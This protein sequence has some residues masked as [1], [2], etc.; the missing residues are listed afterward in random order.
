[1]LLDCR[2]RSGCA[3]RP[4]RR[5]RPPD[6]PG[7]RDGGPGC[8]PDHRSRDGPHRSQHDR[9]RYGAQGCIAGATLSFCLERNKRPCDYSY[10]KPFLH[11]GS[12]PCVPPHPTAKLRRHEGRA[13]YPNWIDAR[14]K[15]PATVSRHGLTSCDDQDMPV[16]CP[17][18]QILWQVSCGAGNPLRKKRKSPV[19]G[20][21]AE[22]AGETL[23]TG[24]SSAG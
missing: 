17:T 15:K 6:T 2:I 1:L 13:D 18:C 20:C 22:V 4:R 23:A 14:L 11:R 3:P 24:F 5:R 16:I 7:M 21:S 12:L 10:N 19:W 8:I 9:A